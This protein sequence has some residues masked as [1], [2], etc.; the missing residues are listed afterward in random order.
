[1]SD[2]KVP[3]DL[4]VMLNDEETL[5][6]KIVGTRCMQ[7]DRGGRL[8][9]VD[10]PFKNI[11]EFISFR[12]DLLKRVQAS[13]E[14]E[15]GITKFK[16]SE[17]ISGIILEAPTCY[18]EP[19]L[20]F[21][22]IYALNLSMKDLVSFNSLNRNMSD[23][24]RIC[25]SSFNNILVSSSRGGGGH[26]LLKVISDFYYKDIAVG[27]FLENQDATYREDFHLF[28]FN[29]IGHKKNLRILIDEFKLESLVFDNLSRKA[30]LEQMDLI[31]DNQG[32]VLLFP[33]SNSSNSAI[34]D[35]EFR[36]HKTKPKIML[37]KLREF[38]VRT[39]KIHVH[40]ERLED[41]SRKITSI[42]ELALSPEFEI[43]EKKI[44]KFEEKS[45]GSRGEIVGDFLATEYVPSFLDEKVKKG[46]FK[47]PRGIFE[48]TK[49]EDEVPPGLPGEESG[50]GFDDE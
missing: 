21:N 48:N 32:S 12:D 28:D 34:S 20:Q 36:L 40:I 22:K 17:K 46:F 37:E 42:S 24:L 13:T 5:N 26:S 11:G 38:I 45:L 44:F 43:L 14:L 50:F 27:A 8:E 47:I 19:S 31:R 16:L 15:K 10:S 25:I 29:N 4:E 30:P 9:T 35:L 6:I 33:E 3:V 39:F 1:M 49:P 41:G 18:R 23:F 2:Y 7:Y